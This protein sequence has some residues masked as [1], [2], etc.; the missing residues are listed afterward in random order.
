MMNQFSRFPNEKVLVIMA[1]KEESGGLLEASGIH[2]HYSGLGMVN[3]ALKLTELI[4]KLQPDRILNLG[5]AG[6][7]TLPLGALVEVESVVQRGQVVSFI[8]QRKKLTTVTDL[9]KAVCG[10]ADYVEIE[11]SENNLYNL[12]DME[13]LAYAQV[14]ENFQIPFHS[15]KYVT[16]SSN[17]STLQDWRKNLVDAQKEFV[18]I[19][20]K[21]KN[22]N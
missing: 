14:C 8:R 1:L 12:M 2:V 11:K 6:S 10:T 15:I 19:C 9:P 18:Q 13:A 20:L 21:L 4:L 16:D 5:T 17:A 7:F 22:I 3:A